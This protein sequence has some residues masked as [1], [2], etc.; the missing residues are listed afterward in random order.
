MLF[1]ADKNWKRFLSPRDEE[2][3]NI[4]LNQVSKHRGAYKNA[5]NI[6]LAQLWCAVLEAK[7]ENAMLYQKVK[8]LEEVFEAAI[9]RIT[10]EEREKKEII[11]SLEGF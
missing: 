8:R 3:V 5:E 10:E 9:R 4:I 7:K 11:E 6:K 2:R 1:K